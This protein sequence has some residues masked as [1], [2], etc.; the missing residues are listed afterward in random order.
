MTSEQ[1]KKYFDEQGNMLPEIKRQWFALE[2]LFR[3]HTETIAPIFGHKARRGRLFLDHDEVKYY[4]VN[5][6]TLHVGFW[7]LLERPDLL[8]RIMP[9]IVGAALDA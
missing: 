5:C 8:D 6:G 7:W 3:D 9:A 4:S 1:K 2:Q